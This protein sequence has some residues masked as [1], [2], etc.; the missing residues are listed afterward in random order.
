MTVLARGRRGDRR[1]LVAG[2][3]GRPPARRARALGATAQAEARTPLRDRGRSADRGRHRL[4]RAVGPRQAAADRRRD[5]G[6]DPRLPAPRPARRSASSPP[7][8]ASLDRAAVGAARP[9]PL[10]GPFRSGARRGHARARH[11][12]DGRRRRLGRGGEAG[13]RAAQP[14][15]PTDPGLPRPTGGSRSSPRP[16]APAQLDRL[17]AGVATARRPARP[18]DGDPAPQ[19]RAA[20]RAAHGRRRHAGRFRRSSSRGDSTP[21]GTEATAPSRSSTSP[22]RRCSRTSGST[23]PRS[24]RAPTSSPTAAS[25]PTGSSSRASRTGREFRRHE[26]PED[27][28]PAGT[29]SAPTAA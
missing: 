5:R 3:N 12:R 26:R 9:R 15:R 6:D 2:A 11:R 1:R 14:V 10:P 23:P 20:G 17:A 13:G 28:R 27:R 8:R 21:R 24:I 4:S 29:C 19:G 18:G 25:R 7:G 22:R 16:D